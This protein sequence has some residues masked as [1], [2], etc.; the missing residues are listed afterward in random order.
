MSLGLRPLKSNKTGFNLF[1]LI[2]AENCLG[3]KAAVHYFIYPNS[4]SVYKFYHL[5]SKK[6][7]FIHQQNQWHQ[8]ESNLASAYTFHSEISLHSTNSMDHVHYRPRNPG[9]HVHYM[10]LDSVDQVHYDPPRRCSNR[11]CPDERWRN[12]LQASRIFKILIKVF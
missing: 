5:S 12:L 8:Y 4:S 10:V 9:N 2:A 11:M 7:K 1:I 6:Y 3:E